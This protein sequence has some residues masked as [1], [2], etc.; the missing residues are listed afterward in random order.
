MFQT[1]DAEVSCTGADPGS[2]DK[3]W[4]EKSDL[5]GVSRCPFLSPPLDEPLKWGS[6]CAEAASSCQ[7][8]SSL[9]GS[10][11]ENAC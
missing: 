11:F 6:L 4:D 8:S 10:P 1:Q 7:V 5:Q 3:N 2:K 9:T